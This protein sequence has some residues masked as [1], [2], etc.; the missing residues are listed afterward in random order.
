MMMKKTK[1]D[2]EY[3]EEPNDQG[4]EEE[5]QRGGWRTCVALREAEGPGSQ[6]ARKVEGCV[7]LNAHT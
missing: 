1:N 3:E 5:T 6:A 7:L 4:D 2:Q